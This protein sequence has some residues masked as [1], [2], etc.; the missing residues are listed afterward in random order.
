MG[1]VLTS[2]ATAHVI[3]D[4]E[5]E[6]DFCRKSFVFAENVQGCLDIPENVIVSFV[7]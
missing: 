2:P 3:G 1:C 6:V 7:V 4:G 5:S